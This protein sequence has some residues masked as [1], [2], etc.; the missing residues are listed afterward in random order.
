MQKQIGWKS[1]GDGMIGVTME[2]QPTSR[3]RKAN[4]KRGEQKC[5]QIMP[6]IRPIQRNLTVSTLWN[7]ETP[8]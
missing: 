8:S 1:A 6:P 7:L 4:F 5:L 3:T 2:R